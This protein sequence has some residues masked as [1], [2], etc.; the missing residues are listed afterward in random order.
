M[1]A[2]LRAARRRLLL[3]RLLRAWAQALAV[4][5]WVGA[6]LL[7]TARLAP[8]LPLPAPWH[9]ALALALALAAGALIAWRGAPDLSAVARL[10]ERRFALDE[11]LSTS[12]E[13]AG[14]RDPVAQ[15]LHADA[16]A[17]A[18]RVEPAR[19]APLLPGRGVGAALLSGVLALAGAVLLPGFGAAEPPSALSAR[20]DGAPAAPEAFVRELLDRHAPEA[21]GAGPALTTSTA[22]APREAGARTAAARSTAAPVTSASPTARSAT[23]ASEAALVERAGE[24]RGAEL[25]TGAGATSDAAPPAGE[26]S[27]LD[28]R[29]DG[30]TNPSY[31]AASARDQELREY[32][33]RRQAA[34]DPGG[35][36]GGDQVAMA[37]AA[38]AGSA[39]AG[40][41]GEGALALPA[42]PDRSDA[43]ELPAITDASGRRVTLDRLPDE[44]APVV[45][46][47]APGALAWPGLEEPPV[48][49][50]AL[51]PADV[52]L[53]RRYHAPGGAP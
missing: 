5:A 25:V 46:G 24:A 45:S 27:R 11:R 47:A 37:D 13:L 9:A 39:T 53:L 31:A 42:A 23:S 2:R 15:A 16:E 22:S 43:L 28:A 21:A 52:E 33:R 12:L 17:A 18:A 38:V 19:L 29:N 36:G 10:A 50:D 32:A 4:L 14:R 6:L 44:L 7:L 20:T 34:G 8:T 3:A 41:E 35:G 51:S 1:L 49:R 48:S 40:F 26:A 30:S